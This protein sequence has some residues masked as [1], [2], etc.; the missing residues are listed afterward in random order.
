[1]GFV[2]EWDQHGQKVSWPAAT[3]RHQGAVQR[4]P[5]RS[6]ART[7]TG[8]KIWKSAGGKVVNHHGDQKRGSRTD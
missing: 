4:P 5:A 3:G 7:L 8:E 1:M 6:A 2:A